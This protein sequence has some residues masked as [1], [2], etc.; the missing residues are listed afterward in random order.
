MYA[1]RSVRYEKTSPDYEPGELTP[2]PLPRD[3]AESPC[4]QVT[5][6]DIDAIDTVESDTEILGPTQ[7]E[8]DPDKILAHLMQHEDGS[9]ENPIPKALVELGV[10]TWYQASLV[11]GNSDVREYL[12]G[13]K[14]SFKG[15]FYNFHALA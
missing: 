10:S 4:H 2:S 14:R 13:H 7:K 15:I 8:G 5:T 6:S 9:G 1:P 12:I 3:G 11:R